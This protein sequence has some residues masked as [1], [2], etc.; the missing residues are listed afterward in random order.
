MDYAYTI[1]GW[2]KSVNGEEVDEQTMMGADGNNDPLATTNINQHGARDAFGY[3][4]SYFEDDY[5]SSNTTMLNHSKGANPNLAADIYN[6]NIGSMFTALSDQ[7]ESAIGTHQTKYTYDQLN[8]IKSMRGFD[9][10]VG[11][12]EAASNYSTEYQYDENGNLTSLLRKAGAS[13]AIDELSYVYDD[14]VNGGFNNRLTQVQD[15][16]GQVLPVDLDNQS[17]NNYE[18]DEIGQLIKDDAEKIASI[19]WTANNKIDFIEYQ[20]GEAIET[21]QF[22]YGAMG[23]RISKRVYSVLSDS[24]ITTYY[25][26]DAQGN[27][28]S[29]YKLYGNVGSNSD[30]NLYLSERNIYGSERVGMEKIGEIIAS[31]NVLNVNINTDIAVITG[32]KFFEMSNHL[33]NVLQVVTDNKLPEPDG[34]NGVDHYVADVVSYSDYYPF[35]MQMPG[36]NGNSSEYDY[37]FNGMLKDDEIKGEGNSYDFGARLYDPRVGRWLSRDAHER[38]YAHLTPY[39]FVNGMVINAIDPDGNDIIILG[40]STGAEGLGHG[41]VLIGNDDKGW[42]YYS[43]DGTYSSSGSSGEPDKNKE[44]PDPFN[45]LEDFL[46]SDYN[47]VDGSPYYDKAFK[48]KSSSSQLHKDNGGTLTSDE[49]DQTMAKAAL[50]EKESNYDVMLSSCIDVCSDALDAGGFDPGIERGF[51]EDIGWTILTGGQRPDKVDDRW[52]SEENSSGYVE[53][54]PNDR[55]KTIEENNETTTLETDTS[56]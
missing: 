24:V 46:D 42:T 4:L 21:I 18:Y 25:I 40:A 27:P 45:S 6:G 50:D 39:N 30:D 15:T 9:R 51:W 13:G 37:G 1:Q 10:T 36:R 20:Q 12:P 53:M 34:Q 56:D 52:Y 47:N 26:L 17:P 8:R 32:D 31:S 14:P 29:T 49:I 35:G 19:N 54:D 3:S 41:A 55:I 2:I 16:E 44:T 43:K 11:V 38:D 7:N 33:G 5:N 22:E 28:M 23:N 48:I